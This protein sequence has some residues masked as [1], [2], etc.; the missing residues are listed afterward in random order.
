MLQ[1]LSNLPAPQIQPGV[2][3]VRYLKYTALIY[4]A[5]DTQQAA[6]CHLLH[7]GS[8]TRVLLS[9]DSGPPH[10]CFQSANPGPPG[11]RW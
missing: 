9:P 7:A 5:A 10:E 3:V 8:S 1:I 11:A 4:S 6:F 2:V